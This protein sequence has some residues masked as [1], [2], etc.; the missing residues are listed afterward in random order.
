ME[1][2]LK[3]LSEIEEAAFEQAFELIGIMYINGVLLAAN[4][5]P[6]VL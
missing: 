5:A 3:N 4:E 1:K 2:V 6:R